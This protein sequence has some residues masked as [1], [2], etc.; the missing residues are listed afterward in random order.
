[1]NGFIAMLIM[2]IAETIAIGFWQKKLNP[3]TTWIYA[4]YLIW[5][6]ITFLSVFI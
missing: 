2:T 3:E 5:I 1:M 6:N 4:I